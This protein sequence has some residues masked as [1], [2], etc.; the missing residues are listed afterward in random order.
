MKILLV[1]DNRENWDM[2]SRRLRARGYEVIIAEDGERAIEKAHSEHPD[3]ILLDMGL[4]K[5]SGGDVARILR[6]SEALARIPIIALTAHVT[7][8]DRDQALNSGCDEFET[9]PIDLERLINKIDALKGAVRV[10]AEPLTKGPAE[11]SSHRHALLN[12]LNHVIGFTDLMLEELEGLS[13]DEIRRDLE[14]IRS[15]SHELLNLIK[16]DTHMDGHG[17]SKPD[18]RGSTLP[19]ERIVSTK[20]PGGGRRSEQPNS[21]RSELKKARV[22]EP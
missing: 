16:G 5:I 22:R 15:A 6:Q 7:D 11:E 20:S 12:P 19:G 17:A 21:H 8:E 3:L 18:S 4:P 1:E 13:K 14:K 9:K 10:P 2:L